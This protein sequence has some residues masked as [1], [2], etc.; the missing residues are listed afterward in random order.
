MGTATATSTN[1]ITYLGDKNYALVEDPNQ[2]DLYFADSSNDSLT[3][4]PHYNKTLTFEKN[5]KSNLRHGF[6]SKLLFTSKPSIN[7]GSSNFRSTRW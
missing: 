2:D 6:N 5:S 3:L 7:A 4:V 1:Y